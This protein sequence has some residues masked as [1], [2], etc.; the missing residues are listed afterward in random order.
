M[1]GRKPSRQVTVCNCILCVNYA[2][3][4]C[5]ICVLIWSTMFHRCLH[6]HK[7]TH[8]HTTVVNMLH[9]VTPLAQKF[10]LIL[11]T[12]FIYFKTLAT[13]TLDTKPQESPI[14]LDV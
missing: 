14:T 8:T 2:Q 5:N 6:C 10:C 7:N 4:M 1:E 13:H 12:F 11:L 3:C 9:T